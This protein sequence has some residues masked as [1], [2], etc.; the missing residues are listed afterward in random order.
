MDKEHSRVVRT[1]I[2]CLG[3]IIVIVWIFSMM[4]GEKEPQ[5]RK[6]ISVVLYHTQSGGWESLLE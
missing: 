1:G 2:I 6:N 4:I 5:E 3:L